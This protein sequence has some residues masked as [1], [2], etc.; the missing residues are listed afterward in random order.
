MAEHGRLRG[1]A[2]S[3][4]G[5]ALAEMSRSRSENEAAMTWDQ[6]VTWFILP[7]VVALI[8][9]GGGIWLSR[10]TP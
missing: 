4:V 3:I 1:R 5:D 8:L 6:V 2:F 10:R 9:G 7:A